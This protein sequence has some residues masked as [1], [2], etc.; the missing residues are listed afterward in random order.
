[1]INLKSGNLPEWYVAKYR[2]NIEVTKSKQS[3]HSKLIQELLA[4]DPKI[5]TVGFTKSL[6]DRFDEKECATVHLVPDA[7]KWVD[8]EDEWPVVTAYEVEVHSV[9]SHGS[10]RL[11]KYAWLW[12]YADCECID[13]RLV[14]VSQFGH[15]SELDLQEQWYALGRH[16]SD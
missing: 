6:R 3:L 10:D 4:S 2:R 15:R 16:R 7:F 13:L 8:E 1:M 5:Q 11:K 14:L 9:I 12:F